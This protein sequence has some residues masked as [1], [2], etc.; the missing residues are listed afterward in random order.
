MLISFT[1]DRRYTPINIGS[2]PPNRPK[3]NDTRTKK[4]TSKQNHHCPA[5]V[6]NPPVENEADKDDAGAGN[7]NVDGINPGEPVKTANVSSC[8]GLWPNCLLTH[9]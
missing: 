5:A 9:I 1:V 4:L 8:V 2:R 6:R 3:P 7:N